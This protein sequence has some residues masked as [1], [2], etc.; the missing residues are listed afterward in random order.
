MLS[1]RD[2][3]GRG[4][5]N[6]AIPGGL[7][8]L[9]SLITGRHRICLSARGFMRLE[10]SERHSLGSRASGV[11]G[12]RSEPAARRDQATPA[13]LRGDEPD[14]LKVLAKSHVLLGTIDLDDS[15]DLARRGNGDSLKAGM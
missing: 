4:V 7:H 12:D 2:G 11:G 14:G 6:D 10:D 8:E 1:G 3:N 9:D 15:L 13:G 5:G